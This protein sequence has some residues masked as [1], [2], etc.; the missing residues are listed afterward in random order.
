MCMHAMEN[1]WVQYPSGMFCGDSNVS[2]SLA[3]HHMLNSR[4]SSLCDTGLGVMRQS[5]ATAPALREKVKLLIQSMHVL[6][7]PMRDVGGGSSLPD[8][9]RV[10]TAACTYPI[11]SSFLPPTP[12]RHEYTLNSTWRSHRNLPCGL[13]L[14]V[15]TQY[16][17]PEV[18]LMTSS[19]SC[20]RLSILHHPRV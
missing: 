17:R 13:S 14:Q 4:D 2:G 20:M 10:Q 1:A 6:R 8:L 16:P 9:Q 15:Y 3:S 7:P 11:L 19:F 5:M 18:F 12:P